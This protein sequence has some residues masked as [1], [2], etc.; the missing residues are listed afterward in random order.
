[1]L[2]QIEHVRKVTHLHQMW[3]AK[4]LSEQHA[5]NQNWN[6]LDIKAIVRE[7]YGWIKQF[8]AELSPFLI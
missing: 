6:V 2:W 7:M 1:M 3:G 4:V 8:K 5:G